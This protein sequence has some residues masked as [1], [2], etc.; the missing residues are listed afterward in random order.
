MALSFEQEAAEAAERFSLLPP[1]APV[2]FGAAG[3]GVSFR[4]FRVFR[5]SNNR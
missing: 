5:G 4:V 2:K 1:L 3:V